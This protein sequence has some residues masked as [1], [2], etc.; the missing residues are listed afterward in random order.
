MNSIIKRARPEIVV[1][2]AY[3]S[4]RS[5]YKKSQGMIF[6]DANECPYEPYVGA[7]SLSR[8]PDQQP[9]EL[10][11]AI[12]NLYD[13][14][15]RNMLIGRGADEIIDVIVRTFCQPSKDNII[16]CPPTFPMY[17]NS[18]LLQNTEVKEVPLTKEFELDV[19][20]IQSN[21][22]DNTKIIF[23]CS[24]NNPTA[25]SMRVDDVE[26][27]CQFLD[28]KALV[29][30][31]ETYKEFSQEKSFLEE[32]ENYPN[33][34]VLRT[35]SKSYASAGLRCGFGFAQS[36]IINLLRKV[37]AVYP[38]SQPIIEEVLKITNEK[39]LKRLSDKRAEILD[40]RDS[41]IDALKKEKE[42]KKIYP[43]DANFLFLEVNNANSFCK[44]CAE[45]NII[46]RNQS[47]QKN[48][49]N[50]VRISIGSEGEMQK[51]LSV[52][53]GEKFVDSSSDRIVTV[54]RKTKETAISVTVNLDQMS[55][56]K[57][58]TGV[59]FYDHMLD[60]IAKHGGFS[61]EMECVGDLEIEAHHTVEDCSIALGE[62]LKKALGDK[63]GIGRYG[64]EELIL[65]MDEAQAKV[66]LDLG[67]RFYLEFVADYP[68]SYVGNTDNPL[69]VDM[70]EHV[71]RSIAE[72]L[73]ATLHI[74]VT[75][76][77]THHMV[78]ACFKGFARALRKAI[79]IEGTDLPS[80]KGK[81]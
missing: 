25:N 17:A 4:A 68:D 29:V 24:P 61:I 80:T 32:I 60:Q 7:S 13:V 33:L 56:V 22:D 74:E 14:S 79:R 47:Y 30:V 27:L 34:M 49:D 52:I 43:S 51:L 6:L 50:C 72:Q 36:E 53:R 73:H 31:D 48:L 37:L 18:A 19:E 39:N 40:R 5:L 23:I 70:V 75:G 55:P 66:A 3:Q 12:C 67:G 54:T 38:I 28:G 2:K 10:V 81:L 63:R 77:N 44:K 1:M 20:S 11:R 35:L 65:P 26:T 58:D 69:P 16:I 15:S 45:N 46:I 71:F 62:A 57:I 64:S 41:F 9:E 21:I 76:E 78:E 8:Y 42:V 59:P